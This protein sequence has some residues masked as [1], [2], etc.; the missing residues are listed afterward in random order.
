M[1]PRTIGTFAR[2][3]AHGVAL[4]ACLATGHVAAAQ[5]T[6]PMAP[7]RPSL[8]Q[9]SSPQ[10]QQRPPIRVQVQVVSTPVV[11]HDSRGALVVDL[12]NNDFRI[13]DNGLEQSVEQFE[14]GGAPLSVAFVV[15]TSSRIEALLPAMRRTGILFTQT[16]M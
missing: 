12:D 14:M 15:E 11:V 7:P 13:Y 4:L 8:T 6:G 16:V 3:A 10:Q 9:P 2:L 1:T 5:T